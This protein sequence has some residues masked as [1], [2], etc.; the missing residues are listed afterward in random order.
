MSLIGLYTSVIRT[1]KLLRRTL[2]IFIIQG[3]QNI[4]FFFTE[5]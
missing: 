3:F 1:P 4:V 5:L 2:M